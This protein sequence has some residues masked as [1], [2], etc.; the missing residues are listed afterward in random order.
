MSSIV[1]YKKEH[2][3]SII[4]TDLRQQDRLDLDLEEI[5]E[6]AVRWESGGPAWSLLDGDKVIG[7]G[8]I[9]IEL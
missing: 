6:F 7:C 4:E 1:Q 8:G 3:Y 9:I 5:K 2:A